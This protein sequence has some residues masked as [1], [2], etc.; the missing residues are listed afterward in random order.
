MYLI[1]QKRRL[2]ACV[3]TENSH[4][5]DPLSRLESAFGRFFLESILIRLFNP[6]L[7]SAPVVKR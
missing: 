5:L 1:A 4:L 3:L 7:M 6:F 2:D